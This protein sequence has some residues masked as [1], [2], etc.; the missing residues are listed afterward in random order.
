[1]QN[2][3]FKYIRLQ[4]G[5]ALPPIGDLQ[6]FK[7]I[8]IIDDE[9]SEIW[10]WEAC[11]WLAL[12][13]C[14]Y[15]MAWGRECASWAEST[16]EAHLEAYDYADVAPENSVVATSHEDE[17]LSEVFWFAKHRASHPAHELKNTVV[18]HVSTEDKRTGLQ[19]ML[20]QA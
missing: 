5:D 10:Q 4:S 17:E 11:R 14:R 6:P 20:E 7:A 3:S 19:E 13:G 1:V 2:N 15:M 9:V 8:V 18:L 16:E 12:S